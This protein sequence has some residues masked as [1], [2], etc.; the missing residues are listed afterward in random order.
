MGAVYEKY[1]ISLYR[2]TISDGSGE[3]LIYFDSPTVKEILKPE[4]A[5]W[6]QLTNEVEKH[7]AVKYY[8]PM[9]PQVTA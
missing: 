9:E 2:G 8:R 4:P 7:G 1:F 3:C 5:M 6:N